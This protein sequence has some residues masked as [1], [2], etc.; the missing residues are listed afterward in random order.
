MTLPADTRSILDTYFTADD[1]IFIRALSARYPDKNIEANFIEL[2]GVPAKDRPIYAREKQ[3][4]LDRTGWVRTGTP[5]GQCET[6]AQHT[7]E[8]KRMLEH[9]M[10][11]N[12][13]LL[14]LCNIMIHDHD[15]AE[16]IVGDFTPFDNI[17]S[18][19][20]H[21][22]ERLAITCI[23][24]GDPERVSLWDECEKG[25]TFTAKLVKDVDKLQ[26]YREAWRGISQYPKRRQHIEH[27]ERG[28]QDGRI[29]TDQGKMVY[30]QIRDAHKDQR[31]KYG[32]AA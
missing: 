22:L 10:K 19:D 15:L 6:V 9:E 26:M 29:T 25:L 30:L 16:P 1:V 4:K 21:S 8:M 28:Y 7:D 12:G 24:E 13:D 3:E 23:Y 2:L 32:L 31:Q 27:V 18:E 11:I 20:K 17:S 14:T 5:S